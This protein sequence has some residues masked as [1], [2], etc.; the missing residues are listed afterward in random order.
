MKTTW[1]TTRKRWG[2][3]LIELLVVVAILMLLAAVALPM[4]KPA[5][6]N[7]KIREA[8]RAINIFF[9]VARNHAIETRR[10]CGVLLQRTVNRP[11]VVTVLQLVEIPPVYVGDT[12]NATIS[13]TFE[14]IDAGVAILKATLP[15]NTISPATIRRGD[16]IQ[17]NHQGPWYTVTDDEAPTDEIYDTTG[18]VKVFKDTAVTFH[19][20]FRLAPGATLPWNPSSPALPYAVARQPYDDVNG[21]LQARHGAVPPLTLPSDVAI[22][23]GVSGTAS[24]VGRFC[25]TNDSQ[26]E[27]VIFI[28][29]PT[30]SVERV[31][32]VVTSVTDRQFYAT[33]PIYLMVGKTSQVRMPEELPLPSPVPNGWTPP[34]DARPNW[35]D[36]ESLWVTLTPQTG[37]VTVAENKY[38]DLPPQSASFEWDDRKTWLSSVKAV[39]QYARETQS[40]KGGR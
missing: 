21:T 39:R 30:G 15:A 29:S 8:A 17:V 7:R 22:D 28:F 26:I 35:L 1:H 2:V 20:A 38:I 24:L 40:A 27:S 12:A 33:E 5:M 6:E 11:N 23:L 9:G 13:L 37:L 25:E 14:K 10:P 16:L 4:V 18:Y 32:S 3:T 34:E 19:L 31:V 36:P